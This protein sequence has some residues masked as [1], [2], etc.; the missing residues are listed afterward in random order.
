ML[1]MCDDNQSLTDDFKKLKNQSVR[2]GFIVN[3]QKP[4]FK[5]FE[6]KKLV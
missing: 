2:F 1:M 4:N 3:V 5:D 6:R